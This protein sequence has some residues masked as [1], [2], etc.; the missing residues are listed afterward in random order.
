MHR[1][2]VPINPARICIWSAIVAL[3]VSLTACE[4][5]APLDAGFDG[6]RRDFLREVDGLTITRRSAQ[7]SKSPDN[8]Y[9]PY[10]CVIAVL[11]RAAGL[12]SLR[13]KYGRIDLHFDEEIIE[14]ARGRSASWR[15]R[16]PI[17]GDEERMARAMDCIVPMSR[18][19]SEMMSRLV[20]YKEAAP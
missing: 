11:D 1:S 2:S 18:E 7:A 3:S 8:A 12:D 14:S 20:G 5:V 15:Y 19:V 9:A 4:T 16:L 6:Q 10:R 17:A 13:Y